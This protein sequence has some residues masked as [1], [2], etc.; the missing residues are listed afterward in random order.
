MQDFLRGCIDGDGSI[1]TYIDRYSA[2][3]KSIYVYTRLFVSLV[4]A[5]PRFL[6]WVQR[7]LRNILGLSGSITARRTHSGNDLWCLRYAKRESLAILRWMYHAP[8]VPCLRRKREIAEP[9]LERREHPRRG[10]PGR[11]NGSMNEHRG[12]G[13]AGVV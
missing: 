5:S 8:D 1:V 13:I 10:G 9:F 3:K 4:S 2:H 12:D 11:P 6:E 7:S